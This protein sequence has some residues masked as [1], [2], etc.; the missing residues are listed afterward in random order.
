MVAILI[1]ILSLLPMSVAEAAGPDSTPLYYSYTATVERVIDGDTFRV[2]VY[3]WPGLEASTAVRIG[4]ID[5]PELELPKCEQERALGVQAK[6]LLSRILP[7]GSRVTI[8]EISPD[9]Y[10]GRV[11]AR[12]QTKDGK[13][14]ATQM[15]SQGLARPYFGKGEKPDWCR[16]DKE[17][18]TN[19]TRS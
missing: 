8:K 13:D 16:E 1:I 9:K 6:E 7:A 2:K 4:G 18:W 5:T 17:H 3:V 19:G 15:L 11:G 14:V 10:F 12:V